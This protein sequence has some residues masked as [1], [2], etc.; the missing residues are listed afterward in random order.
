VNNLGQYNTIIIHA[1]IIKVPVVKFINRISPE[2]RVIFWYW[3]PVN[4][5]L[6]IENIKDLNCEIWSF[7]PDDCKKYGLNENTQFFFSNIKLS[8]KPIEYDVIFVGRD[9]GRLENL[10]KLEKNFEDIGLKCKFHIVSNSRFFNFSRNYI[11]SKPIEYEKVLDLI[12]KSKAILDFVSIGQKGLTIRPIEALFF[13]KK[14]ITND[15]F[16]K[17]LDFYH[18]DNVFILGKD[19]MEYLSDFLEK[20]FIEIEESI[21]S[22][23]D[24]SNWIKRFF[25]KGEKLK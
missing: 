14:L 13:R 20:P 6:P 22:K 18:P 24:F 4:K 19:K 21:T 3:N 7:D 8:N 23:Y 17:N 1:S 25:K 5:I 16:I 15:R 10:L 11:Y 9:K 2:I 12:E